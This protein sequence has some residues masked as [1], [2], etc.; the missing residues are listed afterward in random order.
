M[1][2]GA[3]V[4]KGAGA[5]WA[6]VPGLLLTSMLTGLGVLV[7]LAVDDPHFALEPNYY[8]KAVH[9]DQARARAS[10]SLALGLATTVSPALYKAADGSIDLE[11]AVDDR[12]LARFAG[13]AVE[14]EAFP[15]AY[16]AQVQRLTL[17]EAA[18]GVY[19]GK[20]ERGVLGLWE[21][22]LK[23]SRGS[24]RFEQTLRRDVLS[25]GPT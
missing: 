1:N 3:I 13:A 18:P 6:W 25:G 10:T 22:R 4:A 2:R 16:A 12:T 9:W 20:L 8:D 23:V 17:H 15:N 19:R 21:L 14:L 7:W 11:V 5:L 24:E